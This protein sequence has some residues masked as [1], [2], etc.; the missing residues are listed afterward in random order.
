[1]CF[2]FS[3]IDLLS[4]NILTYFIPV[5]LYYLDLIKDTYIAVK[6]YTVILK[7]TGSYMRSI[8]SLPFGF[9]MTTVVSVMLSQLAILLM[10]PK[11][12]NRYR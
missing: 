4:N 3:R 10:L 2:T 9:F 12:K 5:L 1:M 7:D 8:N 11:F 6:I